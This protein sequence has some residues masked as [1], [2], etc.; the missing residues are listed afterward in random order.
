MVCHHGCYN[1]IITTGTA[2]QSSQHSAPSGIPS[3][4]PA[5]Q[6]PVT[7]LFP[8]L[9]RTPTNELDEVLKAWKEQRGTYASQQIFRCSYQ[10]PISG[11]QCNYLEL[12]NAR[13]AFTGMRRHTTN[14]KIDRPQFFKYPTIPSGFSFVGKT[15]RP[16][17]VTLVRCNL[18]DELLELK[19]APEHPL[20]C[21]MV[22]AAPSGG[23]FIMI[24]MIQS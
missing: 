8:L 18:C 6:G 3:E 1:Q 20:Y 5:H 23:M 11:Q 14:H 2:A 9:P 4:S 22:Q 15:V 12:R 10:H 24:I 13:D 7:N 16:P 17:Q 21:R 19:K